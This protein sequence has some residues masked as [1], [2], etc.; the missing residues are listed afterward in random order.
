MAGDKAPKTAVSHEEIAWC[1]RTLLGREPESE[2]AILSHATHDGLRSLIE[3]IVASPEFRARTSV[4]PR[5]GTSG[6]TS[7]R[8]AGLIAPKHNLA[9][10]MAMAMAMAMAEFEAGVLEVHSSPRV[11]TLETSSRCNLRWVTCA[12][13]ID[14]VNR[15]KHL[16]QDL[17][18]SLERFMQQARTIQLHG[19][20]EPLA[21]PSFWSLLRA[22]PNDCESTINSN[23]TLLDEQRLSDLLDSNLKIIN[24]S[25]DAAR[26]ETYRKIRGHSFET[27]IGN[28]RRLIAARQARGNGHPLLHMNMT[29]MRSNIEEVLEF[30]N[31]AVE[32]GTVQ[33]GLWHLNRWPDDYMQRWVVERDGWVF[34]Y[35][36]EGLWS[37]PA[38]S[39][40]WLHKAEVR[41]RRRGIALQLGMNTQVYFG[42]P[43]QVRA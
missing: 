30:I 43:E 29:L 8:P 38:L 40:D 4:A 37:F 18:T 26:P 35:S 31:L 34:D 22:L 17:I 12:H 25:L 15:P 6:E 33:V 23:L 2:A 36:K 1:Y 9:L 41:A 39:N 28:T 10:A 21:S 11:L 14:A 20:G 24:V 5:S 32:L 27:V 19:I 42:E 13:A 7:A 3:C 16:E